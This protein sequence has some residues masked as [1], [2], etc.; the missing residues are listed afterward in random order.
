MQFFQNCDLE[1]QHHLICVYKLINKL[2][3]IKDVWNYNK[4]NVGLLK[5]D[6][7]LSAMLLYSSLTS[8]SLRAFP[9]TWQH[10]PGEC[11]PGFSPAGILP[12][13][14]NSQ[15]YLEVAKHEYLDNTKASSTEPLPAYQP[16]SWRPQSWQTPAGG[17]P[18]PASGWK[19]AFLH[20][21]FFPALF[22]CLAFF[23]RLHLLSAL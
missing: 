16:Q 12:E 5:S 14:K 21:F 6:M 23:W 22:Y 7:I 3:R 9:A 8:W 18:S 10:N 13:K 4:P 2:G 17:K 15:I 19:T 1:D 11:W 20:C